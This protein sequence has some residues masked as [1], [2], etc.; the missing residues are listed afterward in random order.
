MANKLQNG[1]SILQSIN[2]DDIMSI[3]KSSADH[4]ATFD[5][6]AADVSKNIQKNKPKARIVTSNF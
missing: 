4:T 3:N 2:P 6:S 5:D 1:K